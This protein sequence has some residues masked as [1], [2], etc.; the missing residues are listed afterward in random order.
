[1]TKDRDIGSIDKLLDDKLN[2]QA[3]YLF[4]V[5][6]FKKL[7]ADLVVLASKY[8]LEGKTKAD[9]LLSEVAGLLQSIVNKKGLN[10]MLKFAPKNKA[11]INDVEHYF[12]EVFIG[13]CSNNVNSGRTLNCG[14]LYHVFNRLSQVSKITEELRAVFVEITN[15]FKQAETVL[16]RYK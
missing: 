11:K 2:P 16:Q 15:K 7:S 1:M 12:A 8:Q 5:Y 6:F 3:N 4:F 14:Y 9:R 13:R 10:M